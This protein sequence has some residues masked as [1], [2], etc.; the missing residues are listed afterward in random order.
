[1]KNS[2]Q[3]LLILSIICLSVSQYS[4]QT[5]STQAEVDNW[6]PSITVVSNYITI[7]G[8]DITNIDALSNVTT[9]ANNG[10]VAIQFCPALSN[11]DGLNNLK[12]IPG[13]LYI[14]SNGSLGDIDALSNLES[15]DGVLEIRSN[16]SLSNIDGLINVTS[17]EGSINVSSNINLLNIDGLSNVSGSI[18]NLDIGYND[19]ITN[20]DAL[21]NLTTAI[22]SITINNNS[23]LL[24][25]DG[26][27]N[28]ANN[29]EYL[30][31]SSNNVLQNVDGLSGIRIIDERLTIINNESLSNIDGLSN[32]TSVSGYLTITNNPNLINIDGLS[33]VVTLGGTLAISRN[34]V[35]PEIDGLINLQSI[36]GKLDISRNNSL[37]NINALSNLMAIDGELIISYNESL[38]TI[39]GLSNVSNLE[40]SIR[41]SNNPIVTDIE[42]FSNISEINGTLE[43]SYNESLSSL[44]GL[45]NL[46]AVSGS[47]S[48][49][50]NEQILN[51]DPLINI[52]E[53]AG[54]ITISSNWALANVNGL[55]NVISIDGD[56]IINNNDLLSDIDGLSSLSSIDG[57]VS[58]QYND[59]LVDVDGL[60]NLT[61]VLGDLEIRGNSELL[62]I[63]GLNSL[64]EID[65]NVTI[66]FN[67][68]L[69]NI[70][71]I[72]NVNSINGSLIISSNN[73]LND[74]GGLSKLELLIG[75]LRIEWNES[76]DNIDGLLN[77]SDVEGYL[78]VNWNRDLEDVDGLS[79]L[80][81][82]SGSCELSRNQS[83]TNIDGLDN[84]TSISG[85]LMIEN[86]EALTNV[87][88]L[89][90]LE[91]LNGQCDIERNESLT[92]ID[93]LSNLIIIN[94][95]L[96]INTNSILS[97]I[98]G[99]SNLTAINGSLSLNDN[100]SLS[101]IDALS[102][103][104]S[105]PGSIII[106]N[107][108]ALLNLNGLSNLTAIEGRLSIDSND[109]LTNLDGLSN[110]VSVGEQLNITSNNNLTDIKGLENIVALTGRMNI[111]YNRMLSECCVLFPLIS[112]PSQ[113]SLISIYGNA[114]GCDSVDE[115]LESVCG[116]VVQYTSN[117]PC[118][119]ASNGSID[120]VASNYDTIP[121]TYSWIEMQSNITG[122]ATSQDDNFSIEQLGAGTYSV[123]VTLPDGDEA[124]IDDVILD[125]IASS[126]L[127]I[128]HVTSENSTFGLDNGSIS[129]GFSGGQAP[130]S[131]SLV[132]PTT[133]D[134]DNVSGSTA[135]INGLLPGTY[136][137]FLYD[138]NN[139]SSALDITLVDEDISTEDCTEPMDII[140]L[141]L[142]ST[143]ISAE[144]Y[145]QSKGYFKD[146]YEGI[147]LGLGAGDSRVAFAEWAGRNEQEIK[148]D[149]TGD[150]FLLSDYQNLERSYTGSTDILSALQ[151]GN[152]YL[153]ANAR[154]NAQKVIIFTFDGCASFSAAAYAEELKQSGIIIAD[155]GIGY[156]NS[157]T[158]YRQLLIKAA[159][160]PD[161]AYFGNDFKQID[162]LEMAVS[163]AYANCSG[164]TSN[165]YFNRDGE[166]SI[167]DYVTIDPCPYP[168]SIEVSFTVTALEQLSMPTGT[169]VSFYHNDPTSYGASLISTF[170]IPCSI[171]AG[172]SESFTTILPI[173][174]A[175]QLYAILND[176][177][178]TSPA[179]DLP[180]TDIV[181]STYLNNIDNIRICVDKYATLQALKS[182]VSLYPI[183]ENI[184]QYNVDVCN[185]SGID[186]V[187]INI[188][189]VAPSGFVLVES[190]VNT[191]GCSI[192]NSGTYDIPA[193][194]C[195]SLTLSYDV[196]GAPQDY[197][198]D[199][200]V[201]ID[202]PAGQTYLNF[203]G[204]S[205][206]SE[207]ILL[208]GTEDCGDPTVT[209]TKEVNHSTTCPDHSLTYTY[210]VDNRSS[211]P[212]Y[213]LQFT[214][215]LPLPLEWVYKPYDKQG[216]SIASSQSVEG[217]TASFI[218]DQV[219]AQ[220]LA[221]FVIDVY[222]GDTDVDVI[223]TSSATL[224]GF[225]G[226]INNG[227]D[228]L[229]SN[230][231][232]TTILGD[233]DISVIDTIT[234]TPLENTVEIEALI[235]GA[236]SITW[237]TSG[238]G[239]FSDDG[240]ASPTYTLGEQD[241]LD[242][243]IGLFIS[244]TTYCG[245][246]GVSVLIKR[247]CELAFERLRP[248]EL[249]V[250]EEFPVTLTWSGGVGPYSI[251]EIS[252][253]IGMDTSVDL[254]SLTE[255]AY[256]YTLEDAQGCRTRTIVELEALSE[257]DVDVAIECG[258]EGY[259]D[260][261]LVTG[262]Y[263]I[264]VD[265]GMDIENVSIGNYIISD[266]LISDTI[267]LNILD[268]QSGCE[269][270]RII[271][272]PDCTCAA[273][274]YAPDDQVISCYNNTVMLDG[275]TSSQGQ[276]FSVVWHDGNGDIVSTDYIYE[277][278]EAGSYVLE[279]TDIDVGCSVSDSVIVSDIRNEP[280]ATILTDEAT[281]NCSVTSLEL[282]VDREP[283]VSYTWTYV[284]MG[285]EEIVDLINVD[286]PGEIMLSVQDNITGCIGLDTIIIDIDTAQLTTVITEPLLLNCVNDEVILDATDSDLSSDYSLTWLDDDDMILPDN[287]ASI[288]VGNAGT[289]YFHLHN[290]LNDCMSVDSVTVIENYTIPELAVQ[291]TISLKCS[292]NFINISPSITS[293]GDYAFSWTNNAMVL[294]QDNTLEVSSP[295][296][297]ILETRHTESACT[298]IDTIVVVSPDP[299][300]A[301][302]LTSMDVFC[303][304]TSSG[305]IIVTDILGG[306]P[307]YIYYL[308]GQEATEDEMND[309]SAGEY[310]FLIEDIN[311]CLF[312]TLILIQ[313]PQVI[314]LLSNQE[315]TFVNEG[316]D[317]FIQLTTNI[318]S[319]DIQSV[320]W[321]PTIPCDN[322]LEYLI[323][324][325]DS[326]SEYIVTI[327]DKNGCQET[328]SLRVLIDSDLRLYLPNIM[329][330]I[331]SD[332][333]VFYP[334]SSLKDLIIEEMS[335]HDRWGNKVFENKE[336]LANDPQY[337]WDG[338]FGSKKAI[339]GV[340]TYRIVTIYKDEKFRYAG[341]IT[342]LR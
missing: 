232:T 205:T 337:G 27:S 311:G 332:N 181:E 127:D 108:D 199:Q 19:L 226:Y 74:I 35:L 115:I 195:V 90:G 250:G 3:F 67:D 20:I 183:C 87:D 160:N 147:N 209:F 109:G 280:N 157:S 229:E 225:P 169:P 49:I 99:L 324:D 78:N 255:G 301:V 248:I 2:F 265:N 338:S 93:G 63:N 130:Y 98:D 120:I 254:G 191:N 234:L 289:Y 119:G 76:L 197:Y 227:I 330:D 187:G 121:F 224:Q 185:I 328:I 173:E 306:T 104:T 56:L 171:P 50:H 275:S 228:E 53:V 89:S 51:I 8:N 47:L 60:N 245:E 218:I 299:I 221:S 40:G 70:D 58:I 128:L 101:S 292:E 302:A 144:E 81:S 207:D 182:S 64:T 264:S 335:I 184:V 283:D 308:N 158:N 55:S 12:N 282:Y 165:F 18:N 43:I 270:I 249:C 26:L 22:S 294:S 286:M 295:G 153:Q 151:Y 143:A 342:L 201:I 65:G 206:T 293:A 69:S 6:D 238:D 175:T 304:G 317:L 25:I 235:S 117:A 241:Q 217:Q 123:T 341:S 57:S 150:D 210:Y 203:D 176:G 52:S 284:D 313:E 122:T 323:E 192:D 262:D 291:D 132:G 102:N 44:A 54:M 155:I 71:G 95:N 214:D 180:V 194:C 105:F 146:F 79:N 14:N 196:S 118:L 4:A 45:Q 131:V 336:F 92:N 110:V 170:I 38:T 177:G 111:N 77:L 288:T 200:D 162:P 309:L 242:S 327:T 211:T 72:E 272:P 186:A 281:L 114:L 80:V 100:L 161:M 42:A 339:A 298:A 139:Q 247:E 140:I 96:T 252:N 223:A 236:S 285:T 331:D 231:T 215:I 141:N 10:T 329:D 68:N 145:K 7:R 271:S 212:L 83:L 91:I 340:Y 287:A 36:S 305:S 239:T 138:A 137:L 16:E 136:S 103:I 312:D 166:I 316:A 190:L 300:E 168:E 88:G 13:R 24:H 86:N 37:D 297:Y 253:V 106:D 48:I 257:A 5:L 32:I 246:K 208:D 198:G 46:N 73:A 244:V 134:L 259:Y 268:N 156:V 41:I 29:P 188:E 179:F 94:G 318:E 213:G 222:V 279:V 125:P 220:T 216:L 148:I 23:S 237:S 219:D 75:F 319:E 84:L 243:L 261:T 129:I 333:N 290:N 273:L 240:I 11:I 267:A 296:Y 278:L 274:A 167:D 178:E 159:T 251:S 82:I 230:E 266:I 260:V 34:E 233:I 314:Q 263:I 66:S 334:Q 174:T 21:S 15:V 258:A 61:S 164:S 277:A 124:F 189:D 315:L 310:E 204:A 163:L 62:N 97:N 256:A 59:A 28:L 321:E 149:I 17:I 39:N 307:S 85:G 9:I 154:P 126:S 135:D 112:D 303:N 133:K 193:D 30:N 276:R 116:L 322:C 33:N 202:G 269:F 142:V 1:M 172:E 31:I 320:I 113:H 107:N 325:I 326:D 152:D